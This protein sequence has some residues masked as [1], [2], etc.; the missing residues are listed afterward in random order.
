MEPIKHNTA[1]DAAN[2]SCVSQEGRQGVR[3]TAE[4]ANQLLI[5][6]LLHT[7]LVSLL[8]QTERHWGAV[9]HP[10]NRTAAATEQRI[11]T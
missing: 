11:S 8:Q 2:T 9:D 3:D 6:Q 4:K 10:A 5:T 7:P 1:G